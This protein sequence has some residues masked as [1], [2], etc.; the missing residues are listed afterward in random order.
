MRGRKLKPRPAL[1]CFRTRITFERWGFQNPVALST[2]YAAIMTRPM[3][4]NVRLNSQQE[5]C[6][7]E[8]WNER[9]QLVATIHRAS[10]TTWRVDIRGAFRVHTCRT[11]SDA[12]D[13]IKRHAVN[14]S[15]HC[16]THG[17]V[18]APL[19]RLHAQPG[20]D[21]TCRKHPLSVRPATI[22]TAALPT[23]HARSTP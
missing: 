6:S 22:R 15:I 8:G 23:T 4:P 13:M 9:G 10:A 20:N 3:I 2:V 11:L 14:W 1:G 12:L 18:L 16:S 5:I 7:V 17:H 21:K 19:Q